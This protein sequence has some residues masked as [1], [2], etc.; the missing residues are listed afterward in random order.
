MYVDE[1]ALIGKHENRL[2]EKVTRPSGRAS[3]SIRANSL[4]ALSAEASLGRFIGEL[5]QQAG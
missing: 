4:A 5:L 3:S 2:E 1:I